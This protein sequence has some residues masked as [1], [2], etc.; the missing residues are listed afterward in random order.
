MLKRG[1]M[2]WFQL[3]LGRRQIQQ[4]PARQQQLL[5]DIRHR[6]GAQ[7]NVRFADQAAEISERLEGDDGLAVAATILREF[8][9]AAQ[10]DLVAQVTD[11]YRRSSR[12]YAVDRR[13]YR[14]LWKA[15]G[16]ELRWSLFALPGGLQPYVQV[17]AAVAVLGGEAG[18]VVKVTDVEAVLSHVFEILDLTLIGWEFARVHVDIDAATLATQLIT[19]ARELNAA[20]SN[21]P[22]L[23]RPV[24]EWMRR[25]IT[26]NVYDQSGNRVVGTLNPGKDMREELLA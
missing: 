17:A 15:A 9:D 20:V 12:R 25:N 23:P 14:P 22:P 2:R 24:R 6:Y 5:H 18:R 4:D 13:N 8:A 3:G 16:P 11:L 21:P 26:I 7:V 19:T 10:A 1:D